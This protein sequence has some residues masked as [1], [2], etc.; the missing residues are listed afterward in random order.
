MRSL[1]SRA[2]AARPCI[3][4]FDE[5]ES[6]APQVIIIVIIIIVIIIIIIIIIITTSSVDMTAPG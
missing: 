1:F 4:F 6:L 5:F 3:I 2:Q